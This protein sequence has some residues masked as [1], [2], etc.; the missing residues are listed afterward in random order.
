MVVGEFS[1]FPL[2]LLF[3]GLCQ[4]GIKLDFNTPDLLD[5]AIFFLF[6]FVTKILKNLKNFLIKITKLVLKFHTNSILTSD[7]KKAYSAVLNISLTVL[8]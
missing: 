2:N 5:R 4:K 1:L 3:R 8:V 7:Q 6:S